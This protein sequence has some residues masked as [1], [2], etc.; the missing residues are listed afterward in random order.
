MC[1][2]RFPKQ[3]TDSL[4]ATGIPMI[5]QRQL[6]AM[7]I[8]YPAPEEQTRIAEMLEAFRSQFRAHQSELVKL[9]NLKSGLMTDLP[10]GRV[11]VPLTTGGKA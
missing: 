11:R 10:T 9:Q 4:R 1:S 8:T 7:F 2:P 5:S 3:L 6:S